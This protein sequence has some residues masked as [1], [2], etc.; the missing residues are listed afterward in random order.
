MK[1]Y[2][3]TRSGRCQ[4]MSISASHHFIREAKSISFWLGFRSLLSGFPALRRPY[5][6]PVDKGPAF[7]ADPSRLPSSEASR[8][9]RRAIYNEARLQWNSRSFPL[10]NGG[11]S[12]RSDIIVRPGLCQVLVFGRPCRQVPD[13]SDPASLS[14]GLSGT[15]LGDRAKDLSPPFLL[16]PRFILHMSAPA[17]PRLLKTYIHFNFTRPDV[18]EPRP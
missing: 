7:L 8:R 11:R 16:C 18:D 4:T 6:D 9:I 2:R 14:G 10:L 12:E 5:V 1:Q 13:S 3:L 17:R 15:G